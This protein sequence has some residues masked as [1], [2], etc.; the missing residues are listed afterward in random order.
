[1]A[2]IRS[3]AR[4]LALPWRLGL[5]LILPPRCA[6]CGTVT[7]SQG[8]LCSA[9]WRKAQFIAAPQ[10]QQCGY[11]FELDFGHDVRCGACLSSPPHYDHARAALAYDDLAAHIIIAFKHG[12]RTDLAKTL[13]T[14]MARV[15]APLLAQADWLVPVPLHRKRLFRRR[16][17]QSVLLAQ[18]L[19]GFTT[20]RL[21]SDMILR[22]RETLSQGHLSP[23]ARRRNVEGAFRIAEH[24]Q[25]RIKG[26]RIVLVDDVMT[27][28]ATA[29]ALAR[30]LKKDGAEQVDV[31][32]LA[33]VIRPSV[34]D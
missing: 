30:R 14:W 21:A 23:S 5:D 32:T 17:N 18:A 19:T 15:G 34:P 2:A 33:R 20:A 9:C 8:G 28:G 6:A 3:V 13:G 31:L 11:P 24:W 22:H 7:G 1:M 10:C 29:N 16:Y 27:T 25:D 12:D 26:Q 4:G